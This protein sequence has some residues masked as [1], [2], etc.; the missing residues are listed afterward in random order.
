MSRPALKLVSTEYSENELELLDLSPDSAHSLHQLVS[1]ADSTPPQ[2]ASY[3]IERYSG[4]SDVVLDCFCGG[5]TIPLEAA[6]RGR[7]AY[8]SD[9]SQLSVKITKA[10]IDSCDLQS[11][12][13]ALQTLD[14][15]RPVD[16]KD[17]HKSFSEFF[18]IDTYR[19]IV[20]LRNSLFTRQDSASK[21]LEAIAL[22]LLHGN[23]AGFFSVQTYPQISLL[24]EAQ[25]EL[26]IKRGQSPDYRAIAPRMLRKAASVF[27]DGPI[28]MGR[29]L[30]GGNI[31]CV[32][33]SRNLSFLA[34]NSVHL[35]CT[36]PPL[37][38]SRIF[39]RDYWLRYWFSRINISDTLFALSPYPTLDSWLEF[40][41]ETLFE[42]A[43]V[44]C[45]GGRAVFNLRPLNYSGKEI[46]LDQLLV[47]L[48]DSSL[49]GI[50][51]TEASFVHR[52]KGVKLPGGTIR[53]D[54]NRQYRVIV[55][56]RR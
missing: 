36:T 51:T 7:T 6:L 10:K 5:G 4:K 26:N 34:S 55:L 1:F 14:L 38:G 8:A 48:V 27:R 44:V 13:F 39:N 30:S 21:F 47:K 32:A 17:Y 56:R 52:E 19:E 46:M 9:A 41:N 11:I 15:R 16:L 54:P 33:D 28:S 2:L 25:R 29:H 49:K 42:T 31:M 35:L 50:W 20:N 43:R 53:S 37:P 23:S 12:A 40:M 45:S 24:P 18:D 22:G 3:F